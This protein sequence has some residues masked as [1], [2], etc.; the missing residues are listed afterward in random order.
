MSSRVRSSPPA[1]VPQAAVSFVLNGRPVVVPAGPDRSLLAVLRE[2]FGLISLKNGCEPQ[3]SCGCCTLLVEGQPRLACALQPSQV[4]GKNVVTL[5]GLPEET[6]R[7]LADCFVRAGGVQ[8]GF[9]IPGMAMRAVALVDENP[10]PTRP[11]IA[12]ALRGH[13]CRCT[14]Y[15]KIIDAVEL[16]A[17]IRA[18]ARLPP[19]DDTGRIGT[20]LDRYRGRELTLGDFRYIDDITIPGAAF[21]AL[22]FSDHPRALVKALDTAPALALDGV[23]RIIVAADVPGERHVGLITRDWPILVAVG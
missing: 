6:R 5:E 14:G 23:L 17:Q 10:N 15:R 7:H 18:G 4:A 21:A 2:D 1:P 3:A 22:R 9:C 12:H 20:S 13:L 16:L 11:E 19:G 8:C